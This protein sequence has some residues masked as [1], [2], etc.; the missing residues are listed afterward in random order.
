MYVI[1]V[2][3]TLPGRIVEDGREKATFDID[4][5]ELLYTKLNLLYFMHLQWQ[6][7]ITTC[8]TSALLVCTDYFTRMYSIHLYHQQISHESLI[9][10]ELFSENNHW[11]VVQESFWI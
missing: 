8:Q 7:N 10:F 11:V 5:G 6:I 3:L 4:K 9:R 2:R 1:V